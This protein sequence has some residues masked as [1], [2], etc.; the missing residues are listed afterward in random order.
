MSFGAII[1]AS[2]SSSDSTG[3]LRGNLHFAGQTL[4]EYQARQASL[5]GASE[6][7]IRVSSVTPGLSQAVDR[8]SADG[9]KVSL[10][11]DMITLV[12]DAPRDRDMLLIG[13]GVLAAQSYLDA[14]GQIDGNALLVSDDSRASAPFERIDAGQRWGG[15]ARVTPDLLFGT[16]DMIGE[17]DLELTLVRAAVQANARRITAPQDDLLE[18]RVALIDGQQHADLVGQGVVARQPRAGTRTGGAEYYLLDPLA[19]LLAPV[20]MR[21]QV[22]AMQIRVAAMV[23]AAIGLVPIELGWPGVGLLLMV[24]ALLLGLVA[25]RLDELALRARSDG[26]VALVA[27]ALALVGIG[28]VGDALPAFYLVLLLGLIMVADRWRRVTGTRP[29]M[30]FTPA[31]A[32]I[33]MLG[34]VL[35]G[36]IGQGLTLAMLC[37]IGSAGAI[38]LRRL[39]E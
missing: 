3:T 27:P 9:I 23:A 19:G 12:R 36:S 5:A 31:S 32:V 29:W 20:L 6:I 21:T 22:P 8:L 2:R 37:A 28:L 26:W 34:A 4:V 7:L 30:I 39:P 33:L 16:L 11:R 1:S 24:V 38:I 25:D 35:L 10:I 13:D 14:L 17:W 18:G 15:L